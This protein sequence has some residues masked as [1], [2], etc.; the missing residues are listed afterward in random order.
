MVTMDSIFNC[1]I[2]LGTQNT[3]IAFNMYDT[4]SVPECTDT[5]F[6]QAVSFS[7]TVTFLLPAFL[8]FMSLSF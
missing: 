6:G 5:S 8:L 7:V 4:V 3:G 2:L 1:M